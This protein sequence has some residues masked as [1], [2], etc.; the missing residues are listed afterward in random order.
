[1]GVT[2]RR[3]KGYGLRRCD[4]RRRQGFCGRCKGDAGVSA[5]S[6]GVLGETEDQ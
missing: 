4:L 6:A 1:M 2:G 3:R 5:V